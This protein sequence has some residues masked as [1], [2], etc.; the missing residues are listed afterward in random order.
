[1]FYKK[2]VLTNCGVVYPRTEKTLPLST[3][4]EVQAVVNREK[5]RER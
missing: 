1:M 3:G 4:K 5:G 2:G